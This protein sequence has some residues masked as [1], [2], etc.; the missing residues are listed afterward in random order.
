MNL[1][2][3]P[4]VYRVHQVTGYLMHEGRQC[5]GLCDNDRHE[6]FVSDV[7][8]ESQQ[9]QVVC[10]EYME[11][12]LYHFGQDLVD[13]PAKEA[14]CDLFGMAMAQFAF[15]FIRSAAAEPKV[16]MPLKSDTEPKRT[17]DPPSMH[18]A[19]KVR[20]NR[21]RPWRCTEHWHPPIDPR[22]GAWRV[23]VYEPAAQ[24]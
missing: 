6:I 22:C 17:D 3:G 14:W 2:I 13:D 8:S 20:P 19:T 24:P 23:T 1:R 7:P 9:V 16:K 21:T 18:V 11:A 5:L 4:Y 10:H 12:W 15:D